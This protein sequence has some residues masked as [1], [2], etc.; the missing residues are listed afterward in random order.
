[1]KN[2]VQNGKT[3]EVTL[4]AN[5]ASGAALLIGTL[6]GIAVTS[7]VIGDV[8]VFNTEGVYDLPKAAGAITLGAAVYW[9]DTAKNITTTASGN[10]LIGKC[11][12]AAAGGDATVAVKL[13]V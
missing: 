9:D 2:F 6:L 8:V 3:I 1:M 12:A 11:W 10:T 4:A 5:I 7:G 13:S